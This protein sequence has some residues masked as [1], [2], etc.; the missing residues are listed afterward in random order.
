[1][2]QRLRVPVRSLPPTFFRYPAADRM[3]QPRR[4]DCLW[5]SLVP[6]RGS[7]GFW[8]ANAS[9]LALRMRSSA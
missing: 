2:R 9:S 7:D 8:R 3:A 5:T 6:W 1:M 4:S